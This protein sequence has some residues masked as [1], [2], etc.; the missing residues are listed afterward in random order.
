REDLANDPRFATNPQRV[1]NRNELVPVLQEAFLA[2]TTDE[3]LPELRAVGIPCG[4]INSVSQ[5]FN[6]PHIQ[7]RGY[8]WECDH[9]KAGKIKRSEERRVGKECK[10][11]RTR[12]TEQNKNSESSQ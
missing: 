6:D 2:R 7:A 3:W 8:V 12:D 5:I 1:R 9:P 4:P 11:R 10:F